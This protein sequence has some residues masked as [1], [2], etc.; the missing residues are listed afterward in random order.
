MINNDKFIAHNHDCNVME[1]S[2][3]EAVVSY[4]MGL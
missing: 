2:V 4:R 1:Y 3:G